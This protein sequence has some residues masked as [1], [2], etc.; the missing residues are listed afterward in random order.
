MLEIENI[1]VSNALAALRGMRNPM[2]SWDR[3]DSYLDTNGKFVL[4]PNDFDLC[5]RLVAAGPEHCKFLRQIFVSF[6]V[7]APLHW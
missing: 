7:T 4:G 1:E 2:N 6:D 5:R 3:G